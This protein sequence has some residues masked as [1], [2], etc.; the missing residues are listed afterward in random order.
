MTVA[1][2]KVVGAPCIPIAGF[3]EAEQP[4]EMLLIMGVR[5]RGHDRRSL[6]KPPGGD[7][8]RVDGIARPRRRLR[9]RRFGTPGLLGG[10]RIALLVVRPDVGF[11]EHAGA[12]AW[13]FRAP[14]IGVEAG[15]KP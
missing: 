5:C 13:I 3:G 14:M 2:F 7:R 1:A 12:A 10:R 11:P 9:R 6:G 4:V 8:L 15:Y